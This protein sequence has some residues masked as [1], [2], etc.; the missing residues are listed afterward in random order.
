MS[1]AYHINVI[2]QHNTIIRVVYI[3]WWYLAYLNTTCCLSNN[4]LPHI[5]N[6][7]I[8]THH[9]SQS[10]GSSAG[11]CLILVLF[12]LLFFYKYF[13]RLNTNWMIK[14]KLKEKLRFGTPQ[15]SGSIFKNN[16]WSSV[17]SCKFASKYVLF[18]PWV[19]S[20]KHHRSVSVVIICI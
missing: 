2:S 19:D 10:D 4:I 20:L 12:I 9:R 3:K 6:T 15:N 17:H 16:F 1:S 13:Y 14:E 7:K 8:S 5:T 11:S 18:V